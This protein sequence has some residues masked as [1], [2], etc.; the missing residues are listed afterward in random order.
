M[1]KKDERLVLVALLAGQI[2][3]LVMILGAFIFL[4]LVFQSI[5]WL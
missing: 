4:F 5:G 3:S 2:S 1:P